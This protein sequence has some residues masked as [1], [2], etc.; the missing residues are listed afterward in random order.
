MS[1]RLMVIGL[2]PGEVPG[3]TVQAVEALERADCFYGYGP[4]L[5]RVLGADDPRRVASDNREEGERARE[6]LERAAGGECVAVLSGGDPGV[7]AMAAA[8]CEQIER[9]PKSFRQLAVEIIPG[10]SAMLAAA[11]ACGAPLGHDF[12]AISLSDN[13]KPWSTIERRLTLAAEAGLVMALYNPISKARPWQLGEALERLR[14]YLPGGT[15]VVFAHAAG[16]RNQS[17][18]NTTLA[19]ASADQANMATLVIIGSEQ[20]RVIKRTKQPPL[21]YTPRYAPGF[22]PGELH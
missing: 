22:E 20:T 17:V 6:A 18:V 9:G 7:F 10:V 8:V 16:R 15:V 1:G 12:C 11:A 2:G 19:R 3:M 21:I 5:D 4:Y 13:L 14:D